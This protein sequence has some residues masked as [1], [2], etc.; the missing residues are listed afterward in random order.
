MHDNILN[1][2]AVVS[3]LAFYSDYPSSGPAL[4]YSLSI[5]FLVE[6]DENK[7]KEA[8]FNPFK[9]CL[10]IGPIQLFVFVNL[11]APWLGQLPY[12]G[13]PQERYRP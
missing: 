6:K 7:Q 9:T 5:K 13:W 1:M 4:V 8:E 11:R 10:T 12:P 3:V 2:V